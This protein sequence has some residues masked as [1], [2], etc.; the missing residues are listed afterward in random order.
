MLLRAREVLSRHG[1]WPSGRHLVP[2]DA[3]V[4][5]LAARCPGD[6]RDY[7]IDHIRPLAAFGLDRDDEI[8]LAFAPS[9]HQWLRAGTNRQKGARCC[10][11]AGVR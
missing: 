6:L 5:L 9:N 2:V 4:Q 10:A 8:A 11:T 7:E 3:I 1:K